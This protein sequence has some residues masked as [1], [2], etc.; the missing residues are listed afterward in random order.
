MPFNGICGGGSMYRIIIALLTVILLSSCGTMQPVKD[1]TRVNVPYVSPVKEAPTQELTIGMSI[2]ELCK[3][4]TDYKKSPTIDLGIWVENVIYLY[5][6]TPKY[7]LL[8][9]SDYAYGV[10]V[11][12]TNPYYMI[13]IDGDSV[14]DV[15]TN[16]LHVPYWVV[17]TNSSKDGRNRNIL[18]FFDDWYYIF[19]GNESPRN[20]DSIISLA[21][22]YYEAANDTSYINRDLIYLH[23]LYDH[24]FSAQEY[25]LAL[26]YLAILDYETQSRYRTG[27]HI[28]ILIYTMESNYKVQDY[29]RAAR[30][31]N[32][33]LEYFPD[34]IPGLVYQVLL[35]TN[36]AVKNKLR[37]ALLSKHGEHWLVKDKLSAM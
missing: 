32:I 26:R 14:L 27:M 21:M 4:V 16:F 11:N 9:S 2:S 19:Q 10:L 3:Q 18:S 34:C 22:E 35:E 7:T 24:L 30:A 8:V 13:D 15:K 23:Q 33:L 25:D 5:E 20:T 6:A 28:T 36:P 29:V 17:A 1:D 31:T 12:D 37:E